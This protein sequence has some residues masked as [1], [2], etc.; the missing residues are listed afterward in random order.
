[1][2][3]QVIPRIEKQIVNAPAFQEALQAELTGECYL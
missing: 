1:M 2:I 3:G